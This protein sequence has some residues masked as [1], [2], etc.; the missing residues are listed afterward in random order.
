MISGDCLN[1]HFNLQLSAMDTQFGRGGGAGL[2]VAV[3]QETIREAAEAAMMSSTMKLTT[4]FPP[5]TC[6]LFVLLFI[7]L[8]GLST[9][10]QR[11]Y[12]EYKHTRETIGVGDQANGF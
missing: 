4:A 12:E 11:T 10:A 8:W 3:T 9:S 1:I 7:I 6:L 5:G 2:P